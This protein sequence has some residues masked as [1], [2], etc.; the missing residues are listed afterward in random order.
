MSIWMFWKLFGD[1]CLYF[2]VISALPALFP[3]ELPMLLLAVLYGASGFLACWIAG[4]GWHKLSWLCILILLIP[5]FRDRTVVEW[6]I[7]APPVIYAALVILRGDYGLE[8]LEFRAFFRKSLLI[9]IIGFALICMAS[10]LEDM[11]GTEIRTMAYRNSL[12]M[13]ICFA[14]SGIALQIQLRLGLVGDAKDRKLNG[15]Y[16]A[17]I[18]GGTAGVL[19][20]IWGIQQW[21]STRGKAIVDGVLQFLSD[22]VLVPIGFF[23]WLYNLFL[24]ELN[25]VRAPYQ[26]PTTAPTGTT[27]ETVSAAVEWVEVEETVA[28]VTEESQTYPWWLAILIVSLLLI[29]LL[30]LLKNFRFRG[31]TVAGTMVFRKAE[32]EERPAGETRKSPRARVRRYYREHLRL[33]KRRGVKLRPN[34]TSEDIYAHLSPETDR[35]AAAALRGVYLKARYQEDWDLSQEDVQRAKDALKQLKG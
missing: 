26:P 7:M 10:A 33:E 32:Q 24:E 25:E 1:T 28:A 35:N 29:L 27:G 14:I 5:L 20:A 15:L 19:A 17:A 21:L 12:L 9:W 23:G 22:L 34:Q 6:I 16:S 11:T 3:H 2:S 18:L 31:R 4:R 13:G 8:Y 30:S